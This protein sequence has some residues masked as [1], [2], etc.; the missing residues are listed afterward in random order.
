MFRNARGWLGITTV[1]LIRIQH[2]RWCGHPIYV[3]SNHYVSSDTISCRSDQDSI[4][5]RYAL[6]NRQFVEYYV[7]LFGEKRVFFL[8]EWANSPG[9]ASS[10]YPALLVW[11]GE[12][13][14]QAFLRSQLFDEDEVLSTI[15]CSYLNSCSR[16]S[17]VSVFSP[18][19]PYTTNTPH[20]FIVVYLFVFCNI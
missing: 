6:V 3:N 12:Y 8:L 10:R 20:Q 4:A 11:W 15:V 14:Q 7:S 13:L 16:S 19:A 18:T 1:K 5:T 17:P 9:T 2:V